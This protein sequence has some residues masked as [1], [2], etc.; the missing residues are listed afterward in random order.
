MLISFFIFFL[1]FTGVGVVSAF[2]RRET[3]DD[4]LLASRQVPSWLVGLSFGATISSGATFIGF[5]G[6]AYHSGITAIYTVAGLML[7]D[8]IGWRIAGTKIRHIS[9]EKNV[10]TFPSLVGKLSKQT[11]PLVTVITSLLTI[12]FMG[13]YC[14]AQLVAGAKV[15]EALFGWDFEL[16]VIIGAL[17]LLAY[18]WAGGIR[19]SIWT[20]ALQ[21]IIILFS[22]IVLIVAG[23]SKIGGLGEMWGQLTA[24]DPKLTNP[25]QI[26]MLST[27]VGWLFFG[28]GILGQPQLMVRHMVA[29]HD[30]D[31]I[32]ARRIY[33]GWRVTVLTMAVLSGLIARLLIPA[34]EVFDPELSIPKLWEELLHPVL[35]GLLIAGLFSATMSTADSLLLAA[36]S[37]LSQHLVPKWRNSYFFARIATILVIVLIVTIAFMATKGVLA[38][39]IIAWTGMASAVVPLIVVQLLGA[40]IS[41]KTALAMMGCGFATMLVWRYGLGWHKELLDLAPGMMAGF[42]VYGIAHITKQVRRQKKAA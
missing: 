9:E 35:V 36:S 27:A 4:Y 12:I 22:L 10:H 31:I 39:V 37:A 28:I 26:S 16:F 8:Y 17:V 7:G 25:F 41:Q 2:W 14:S 42:V 21:A 13:T 24:I 20:D 34:T 11:L 15:G 23:L 38:L 18:C 32:T 30:R 40:Q 29:R 19:A 3:V 33:V 6:L 1:L 5:A